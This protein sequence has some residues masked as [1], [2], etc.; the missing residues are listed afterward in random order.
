MNCNVGA[1]G[2]FYLVFGYQ[3]PNS[4]RVR[5]CFRLRCSG[6]MCCCNNTRPKTYRDERSDEGVTNWAFAVEGGYTL[7]R[8]Q[9][10]K[11][12]SG[13]GWNGLELGDPSHGATTRHG[14]SEVSVTCSGLVLR[15]SRPDSFPPSQGDDDRSRSHQELRRLVPRV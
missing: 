5:H 15:L 13:D 3:T 8:P 12:S 9:I 1:E 11:L 14:P 6:V 7:Q 2:F 10:Q 4:S